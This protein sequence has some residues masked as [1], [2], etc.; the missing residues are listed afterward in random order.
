[1]GE[2][3]NKA[4]SPETFGWL[5]PRSRRRRGGA[6]RICEISGGGGRARQGDSHKTT[7][8]DVANP[9]ARLQ[10]KQW[11]GRGSI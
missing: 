4:S 6:L 8:I 5:H 3:E 2:G 11:V 1:M 7:G 10:S 9:L